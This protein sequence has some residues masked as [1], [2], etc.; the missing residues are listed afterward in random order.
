MTIPIGHFDLAKDGDKENSMD[1]NKHIYFVVSLAENM[2][3]FADGLR[4]N[5]TANTACDGTD[6]QH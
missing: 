3:Q 1:E 5:S 2:S 4:A 6:Q